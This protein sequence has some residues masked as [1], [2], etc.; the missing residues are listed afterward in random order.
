MSDLRVALTFDAEH[1]DRP[2]GDA[3]AE[4]IVEILGREDVPATFFVQGRWASAY[5]EIARRIGAAGHLIGNHSHA[6]APLTRFTEDGILADIAEAESDISEATGLD[7]RP[8]FRCPFGDGVDDLVVLRAISLAGYTHAGWDI[9]A[10]DW[11]SGRTASSLEAD[12]VTAVLERGGDSVVLLHTW[13]EATAGALA[14]II[15]RLRDRG[16][17]FV[18]LDALADVPVGAGEA[19]G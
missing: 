15:G 9:D 5:P 3:V 16:A 17:A 6:H 18:R 8:W 2:A 4:A 10:M 14:G 7:P 19:A 12:V 13:P 11:E 1:P